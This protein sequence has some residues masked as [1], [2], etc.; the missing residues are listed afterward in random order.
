MN[1]HTVAISAR[2]LTKCFGDFVAVNG[3][4]FDVYGGEI[5]GFLGPNGSGKTTTIRMML[6]L[7]PPSSGDVQVLGIPVAREPARVRPRVGY[8]SQRFSLYNDLTVRQNLRF[9]GV[10]YGLGNH[11]IETRIAEAVA[12]AGLTGNESRKTGELSG[13]WRQRLALMAAVLH[14]PEVLVLDEPTAG[15]DPI[16]RR[17]FWDLLYR[18][19]GEGVAVFV[20]TH[21][22]DEAEHCHR[23]AFIQ[24]GEITAYGA[25]AEIKAAVLP[26][27]VLEIAP[28]D[29]AAAVKVLRAA[30]D[31]GGFIADEIELYG[32]LVH[33]VGAGADG[34]RARVEAALARAGIEIETV[35]E[36]EPSLEDVFIASLR[37]RARNGG[38]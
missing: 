37:G 7:L 23:L 31:A 4:S 16:S 9:Y 28:S 2:N 32:A 19:I 17:A 25:P 22:M 27:R 1:D 3:V 30:R 29:A 11:E 36:I 5:F 8:M 24:R 14:R 18:L 10:A 12:M 13:G 15:V 21:Y 20:T 38:T 6:G 34:Q 26:G 35:S 33:V